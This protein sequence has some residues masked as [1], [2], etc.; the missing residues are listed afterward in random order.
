METIRVGLVALAR[1]TFD[2][3]WAAEL[4]SE[5]RVRLEQ[6]GF[7][8]IGSRELITTSS[9]AMQVAHELESEPLDL[10]V[11]LQAT[12]SDAT[13]VSALAE[14]VD[15]PLLLWGL[16]EGHSEGGR[17]RLNSLCGINLAA[18]TLAR[19]GHRYSYVYAV[20]GDSTAVDR[21]LTLASAGRIRHL[22]RQTRVGL[23]GTHPEG[24]DPCSFD[25]DEL[26]AL[27]GVEVV[28]VDLEKFF[29]RARATES[30]AVSAVLQRLETELDNLEVLDQQAVRG[31]AAVYVALQQVARE[32]SLDALA[33][34][35]WPEFFTEMGCAACGAM[36]LLTDEQVPCG[37]E[38]DVN[39]TVTQLVLQWL[40]DEPAFIA[41]LVSVHRDNN[42]A[43]VWHCGAAPLSMTDPTVERRGQV[44]PNRQIPLVM[45][46]PL[47]PGRVTVARLSQAGTAYRLVIGGG[48]MLQAPL[49]FQGNSGVLRFDSPVTDV[50]DTIM[51]NG[52][53]HHFCL[54]YGDHVPALM[55][56]ADMLDLPVLSL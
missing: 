6:A 48:E 33:V 27:L 47:K 45:E 32:E 10:L 23:I 5:L 22:L 35:C 11:A 26:Q 55:A 38:A 2:V 3:A 43:V 37:C 8:L 25:G 17:L 18:Y 28:P 4:T 12:F 9:E 50:L 24:F 29:A 41:D 53:E 16:P 46:F 19:A 1:P 14:V 56:L 34:R 54:A 49:S 36:S 31:T 40:S 51:T 21:V 13:M 42:T 15:A 44:H 30:Q 7:T 20:P 39:G 52:L